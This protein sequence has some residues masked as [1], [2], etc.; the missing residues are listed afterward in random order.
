MKKDI[1]NRYYEYREELHQI[2]VCLI[3]WY[4]CP[5]QYM[6]LGSSQHFKKL[7]GNEGLIV[8]LEWDITVESEVGPMSTAI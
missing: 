2:F 4:S 3:N 1:R 7:K 6:I 5:S 8:E